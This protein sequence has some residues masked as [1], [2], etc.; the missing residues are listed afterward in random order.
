[1]YDLRAKAQCCNVYGRM[2]NKVLP[3]LLATHGIAR[4][5]FLCVL[6]TGN[7]EDASQ[8]FRDTLAK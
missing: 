8:T 2:A 1:M 5:I 6:P 7:E 4:P 3:F